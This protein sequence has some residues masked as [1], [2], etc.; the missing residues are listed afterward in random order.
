MIASWLR[1]RVH[2]SAQRVINKRL[3]SASGFF[4][5]NYSVFDRVESPMRAGLIVCFFAVVARMCFS[6]DV[7]AVPFSGIRWPGLWDTRWE[8][9][10]NHLGTL[11]T[12]PVPGSREASRWLNADWGLKISGAFRQ[13]D[14]DESL[15]DFL[16]EWDAPQS[17]DAIDAA[18]YATNDDRTDGSVDA[19]ERP[20][21]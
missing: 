6:L 17:C 5:T 11:D 20:V 4:S 19:P 21:F 7:R 14:A 12:F 10:Q 1:A 15:G 16:L 13:C 8:V 3:G 18:L 2:C 9:T